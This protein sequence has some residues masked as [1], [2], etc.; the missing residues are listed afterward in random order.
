MARDDLSALKIDKTL[1]KQPLKA[2]RKWTIA[3]V[4][5]VL[6]VGAS[7]LYVLGILTPSVTVETAAVSQVYPS[8]GLTVLNASG[9]VVAQRK[10]AVAS[11]ATGR[12]VALLVEEGSRVR[13]G[14]IIARLENEDVLASRDQAAAGRNVSRA[15]LEQVRAELEEARRDYGRHK[16]LVETGSV[17]RSAY[18]RRRQGCAGPKRLRLP[19]RPR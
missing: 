13:K 18:D 7:V 16:R 8:Q 12:L 19:R 6:L 11:K 17:S 15:N 3:A 2:S 5:A 4:V 14:Q 9:Y 1:R 10:A